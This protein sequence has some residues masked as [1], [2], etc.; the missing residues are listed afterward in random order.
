M[1]LAVGS[2]INQRLLYLPL[3]KI[4]SDEFLWV[5]EP[6]SCYHAES[7]R[8]TPTDYHHVVQLNVAELCGMDGAGKRLYERRLPC[9]DALGN[10]DDNTSL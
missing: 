3:E 5:L 8:A 2:R 4:E 1:F 7:K 9:W 6:C 10:L